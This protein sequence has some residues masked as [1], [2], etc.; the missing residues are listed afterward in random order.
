MMLPQPRAYVD[1]TV[2]CDAQGRVVG[3]CRDPETYTRYLDWLADYLYE[4]SI[5]LPESQ[6][7]LLKR[8]KQKGANYAV[9]DLS[10]CLGYSIWE[11]DDIERAFREGQSYSAIHEVEQKAFDELS[12]EEKEEW[13]PEDFFTSPEDYERIGRELEESK[14]VP[15][16]IRHA[17]IPYR[18]VLADLFKGIPDRSKRRE[19][20]DYFYRNFNDCAS[21]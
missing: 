11:T 7:E 19:M 1:W 15:Q 13:L 21:K 14:I 16:H 17:D 18:A 8:Y 12:E 10:D 4:T 20:L 2:P 3:V 6:T 9:L 5:P